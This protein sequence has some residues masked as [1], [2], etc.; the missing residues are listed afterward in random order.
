MAEIFLEHITK[1]Y[2]GEVLA[3]D[4]L[5]LKIPDKITVAL[6][7]PSG[8]GKTTTMRTIAGLE[9]PTKGRIY[10]DGKDVTNLPPGER[11]VAM[12]FQFPVIHYSM[13][14][15]ENIAFPLIAKKVSRREI[16]QRVR[17]IAEIFGIT[18]I[19]KE[20]PRELNIGAKQKVALCRCF[21]RRP[22]IFLLDEPLTVLDP[23]SRVELRE[24]IMEFRNVVGQTMIY[25]THDQS[26]ALTM[27]D[28]IAVMR[29]GRLLQYD[30]PEN[31]YERPSDTFVAWFIGNPGMN[32]INCK[33][34]EVNRKS[35]LDATVF[36]Y[37]VSYIAGILKKN[38]KPKSDFVLGIRPEFVEVSLE[39]KRGWIKARC[40]LIESW[41]NR[42]VLHL[43][44]G[45][46]LIKAKVPSLPDGCEEKK[47]LWIHFPQEHVRIFNGKT[48]ALIV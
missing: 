38:S 34:K 12:V 2:K 1:I 4:D 9:E 8:C 13:S 31:I 39:E 21:V 7:G 18:D 44:V 32:F 43:Q 27:G 10:I 29:K 42:V 14:V 15:F 37:D 28:R 6:L 35:Y 20:K 17:E 47:V 11:N 19:L 24:R 46:F 26:E 5:T 25:V 45:D 48:K 41:G 36:R 16:I 22:K 23:K 33:F 3:V 30:K 40:I